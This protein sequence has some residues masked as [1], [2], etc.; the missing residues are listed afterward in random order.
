[1]GSDDSSSD[2]GARL[3]FG[4]SPLSDGLLKKLTP[5]KLAM[6]EIEARKE[7]AAR[8]AE[9]LMRR[10]NAVHELL[11]DGREAERVAHQARQGTHGARRPIPI[12][13]RHS[14]QTPRIHHPT[15]TTKPPRPPPCPPRL[16]TTTTT[17][18]RHKKPWE[19]DR[20]WR[21]NIRPSFWEERERRERERKAA[22][23]HKT[24]A[25][26]ADLK[27]RPAWGATIPL[28]PARGSPPGQETGGAGGCTK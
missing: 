11:Q 3:N 28:E 22:D 7:A 9:E 23:S 6:K 10:Q 21:E 16:S 20:P 14:L 15:Q 27:S 2:D 25:N 12:E 13:L 24:A 26:K 1:M 5:P 17:A 8:E 19:G 4:N 18:R